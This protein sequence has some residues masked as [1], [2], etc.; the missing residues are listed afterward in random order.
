[1]AFWTIIG[2]GVTGDLQG[3]AFG[4][5]LDTDSTTWIASGPSVDL[6]FKTKSGKFALGAIPELGTQL[7][8]S[9]KTEVAFLTTLLGT[10]AVG[11]DGTGRASEKGE[12]FKWKLDSK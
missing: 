7:V 3:K 6:F 4:L 1:M 10:T 9:A 5:S 2:T 11:A 8:D 12:N